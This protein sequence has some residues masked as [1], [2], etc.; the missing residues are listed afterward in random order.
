MPW[1]SRVPR[2]GTSSTVSV[3]PHYRQQQ[4]QRLLSVA[5]LWFVS[6]AQILL[7]MG[8]LCCLCREIGTLHPAQSLTIGLMLCSTGSECDRSVGPSSVVMAAHRAVVRPQQHL[9][10]PASRPR[11]QDH[12]LL[13]PNPSHQKQDSGWICAKFCCWC[14]RAGF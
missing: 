5:K 9:R 11:Q 6:V 12:R 4:R 7:R 13:E 14:D 8:R 1:Q 2:C 10:E 3:A